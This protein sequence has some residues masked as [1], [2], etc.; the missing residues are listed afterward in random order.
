MDILRFQKEAE[1][2]QY[3]KLP[4]N[5]KIIGTSGILSAVWVDPYFGFFSIDGREGMHS[6]NMLAK[7]PPEF[8]TFEWSEATDAAP[9][10]SNAQYSTMR[11][12]RA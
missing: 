7:L 11:D 6:I 10:T 12:G 3:D 1:D 2:R 5:F 9:T 4:L 8:V